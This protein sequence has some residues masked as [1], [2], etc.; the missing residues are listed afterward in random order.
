M[1]KAARYVVHVQVSLNVACY[2]VRRLDL[3][4]G[5]VIGV[6]PKRRCEQVNPPDFLES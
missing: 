2:E 3:I 4:G 6:S 5:D 1:S